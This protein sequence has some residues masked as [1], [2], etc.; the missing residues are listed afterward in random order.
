MSSDSLTL[1]DQ[2]IS[3]IDHHADEHESILNAFDLFDEAIMPVLQKAMDAGE[4]LVSRNTQ[5]RTPIPEAVKAWIEG[6]INLCTQVDVAQH[7]VSK[8]QLLKLFRVVGEQA[9]RAKADIDARG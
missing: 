9:T 5:P 2:I 6:V 3:A 1:R 4:L 7:T 8:R